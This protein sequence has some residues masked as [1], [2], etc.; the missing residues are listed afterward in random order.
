MIQK[1]KKRKRNI[2]ETVKNYRTISLENKIEK[3]HILEPKI[4]KGE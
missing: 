3:Q 4:L 1:G 2:S